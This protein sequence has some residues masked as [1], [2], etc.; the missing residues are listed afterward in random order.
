[1]L[2]ILDR[3]I[4]RALLINY[5]I[6][7]AVMISLYVVLDLFVNMDEFTEQGYAFPTVIR[8]IA[9]YY[10]PNLLLYF[11]QLSGVITLFA[12]LA[13]LARMRKFNEL[14]AVLASGVSLHRV[15]APIITF[16][17]VSTA[18]LVIDSEWLIPSVAHR[19]ARD[20]DDVDG[21]RAYGVLFLRD[22]D[23]SL[24]SAAQFHPKTRDLRSLL[25]LTRNEQ[26]SIIR[27]LEADRGVWEPPDSTRPIGRWRLQ[28]SRL[29]TRVIHPN[30]TLGPREG[31]R[32]TH[33]EFYESD[34]SPEAIQLRQAE[35]WIRFLSLGQLRE[36]QQQ[37]S[38]NVEAIVRTRHARIATPLVSIVLLLLGL[39]FFL[40]RSPGNVTHDTGKCLLMCGL[41]YVSSFVA[42]S[43]RPEAPSALLA[44]IPI[45]V[46]GTVAIV[47][48]DR[49]RT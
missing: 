10:A 16:G 21:T 26:G 33:P 4:L 30:E 29:T 15:A 35:G 47:L 5:G 14:T 25:V 1:M 9:D 19:L 28:R 41:C 24:L 7:L 36:L 43:I 2:T 18:L 12:C 20:R 48:L 31:I 23:E 44:W 49:V 8:N 3:Y 22:R 34:L 38:S 39:P 11:A 42:Q 32:V 13:S 17:L 46:F 40:N 6:A 37:G 27:T 45:F